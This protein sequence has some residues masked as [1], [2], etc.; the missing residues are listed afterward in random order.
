MVDLV[1]AV[2]IG[3]GATGRI[4]SPNIATRPG[5]ERASTSPIPTVVAAVRPV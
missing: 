1:T 4:W 5:S 3:D 2:D